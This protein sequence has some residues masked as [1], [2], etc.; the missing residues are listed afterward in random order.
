MD[1]TDSGF[2][3][4]CL[5]MVLANQSGW[6]I[7]APHGVVADWNGGP[8]VGDLKIEV[9]GSPSAVQT[10]SNVGSGI[11]T[12]M[13]PYVFRTPA[14]WNLLCRGPANVVKDGIAPL[15]GLVETDWSFASFSMNWKFTRPGRVEFKEGE[16]IAMLVPQRRLDLEAFQPRFAE[17]RENPEL[18]RGY[19]SWI[20]SRQE[21]WEDQRR[22]DPGALRQRFQKHYQKGTTNSGAVFPDHQKARK[23]APFTPAG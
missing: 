9:V 2:A 21:F 13:I 20:K 23:L 7:L 19:T 6:F 12:W 4:H 18:D 5:P 15:E 17:L 16:P 1:A 8:D 11:L 14:G 10:A 3:Y 22:G